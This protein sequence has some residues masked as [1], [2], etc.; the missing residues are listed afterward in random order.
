M[1]SLHN[2]LLHKL[3]LSWIIVERPCSFSSYRW[4]LRVRGQRK[5]IEVKDDGI[6][7]DFVRG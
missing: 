2:A 5:V 3:A 1:L 6:A 7:V 4:G